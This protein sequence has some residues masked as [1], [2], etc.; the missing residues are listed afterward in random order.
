MRNGHKNTRENSKETD[1]RL[2]CLHLVSALHPVQG[3]AL[4][5]ELQMQPYN[6]THQAAGSLQAAAGLR[7]VDNLLY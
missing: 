3:T 7:Q 2:E 5:A 4:H 6:H 1:G